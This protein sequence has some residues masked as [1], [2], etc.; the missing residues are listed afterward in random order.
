MSP[1]TRRT[2]LGSAAALGAALG[3][4]SVSGLSPRAEAATTGT[5]TDVQHVVVLMQENRSFD[6]YFGS[7]QGVRGFADRSAIAV[8]GG[9]SVFDQPNGSARQYP[10]QLSD[11]AA[12]DSQT[13]EILAQCDGSLDHGWSTQHEAWDSGKMDDWVSAKGSVRTMGYLERSD[14]PF[15]YALA[16]NYTVCDAYHCSIISA[17]GPNRTYLW[18]G[19]IDP[20]GTAGGPA[21]DG[22]SESGLTWQT[23]A[24]TLQNAGVSWKVYQNADDNFTDNALQYPVGCSFDKAC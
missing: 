1:L 11:T 22:G 15:H 12:A 7:L 16:D 4:E 20:S 3:L 6:H 17:T 13:P 18:S 19:M 24:E 14:I 21:N 8:A 5:I 9:Y 23:Y 10:W 2:F